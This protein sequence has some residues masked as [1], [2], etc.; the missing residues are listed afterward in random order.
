EQAGYDAIISSLGN[1][2]TEFVA[3]HSSQIEIISIQRQNLIGRSR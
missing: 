3:F 1:D 2:Q